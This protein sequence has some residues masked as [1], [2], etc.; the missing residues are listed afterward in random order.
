[1]CSIIVL[2]GLS[3]TNGQSG[4]NIKTI[5]ISKNSWNIPNTQAVHDLVDLSVVYEKTVVDTHDCLFDSRHSMPTAFI[6]MKL[7]VTSNSEFLQIISAIPYDW[8]PRK[9]VVAEMIRLAIIPLMLLC[10]APRANPILSHEA[11]SMSFSALLGITNGY[12]GSIPMIMA[13]AK[14]TESRKELSGNIMTLS[15]N[16]GLTTGSATAYLL[17]FLLGASPSVSCVVPITG[18]TSHYPH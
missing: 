1:M 10:V 15:C 2:K 16:V 8:S 6:V 9:L 12:F 17:N 14:V 18:N 3:P 5:L 11:W 13:P 4:T 7:H